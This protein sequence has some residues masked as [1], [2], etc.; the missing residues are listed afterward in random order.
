MRATYTAV[1]VPGSEAPFATAH[2]KVFYAAHRTADPLE[3]ATGELP[4][5]PA[6][7]PRPVVLFLPGVNVNPDTYRWLAELLVSDGFV[8]VVPH[9]VGPLMPGFV[10]ITPGVDVE[11]MTPDRYGTR[12]A[13]SLV[14]PALGALGQLGAEGGRL[15]GALDLSRVVVGGHSAGGSMALLSADDRWFPEV[16]GAFAYGAHNQ[17][18]TALGWA[19]ASVLPYAGS[20][21][22]LLVAGSDDG[23]IK[24]SAFRYGEEQGEARDPVR[25]TFDEAIAPERD[26]W[27]VVLD[28]A[29]HL[30]ACH[31]HDT[32]TARGFLEE[33]MPLD[34][35][36]VTR[37]RYA[38]AVRSFCSRVTGLGD[39]GALAALARRPGVQTVRTKREAAVA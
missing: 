23:V 26:A 7:G 11:A 3:V 8:V 37:E 30:L 6:A 21:P 31:P 24:A 35:E 29:N 27:L 15:A 33:P 16:V 38:E 4:P 14:R 34:V 36:A 13:C 2:L 22:L 10:G 20:A 28:G 18:S 39:D 5:D 1:I 12:P 19:P 25:R 17:P 9:W 32:S